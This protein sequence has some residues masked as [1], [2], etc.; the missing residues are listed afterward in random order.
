M[1]Y[2]LSRTITKQDHWP[3]VLSYAC[4]FMHTPA[5][6]QNTNLMLEPQ[7]QAA[8][9]SINLLVCPFSQGGQTELFFPLLFTIA[10]VIK[11][12][13][14][15]RWQAPSLLRL[16]EPKTAATIMAFLSYFWKVRKCIEVRSCLQPS[17]FKDTFKKTQRALS[18]PDLDFHDVTPLHKRRLKSFVPGAS[19]VICS[20]SRKP[21]SPS[22]RVNADLCTPF[23]PGLHYGQCNHCGFVRMP[24]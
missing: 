9:A 8:D 17:A 23:Q 20:C 13:M 7:E 1:I 11:W 21:E 3:D 6:G 16:P 18:H 5:L 15:I 19:R 4:L 22:S 12:M 24:V 14:A 10:C 2:Q